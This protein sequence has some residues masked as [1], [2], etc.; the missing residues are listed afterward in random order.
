MEK[1]CVEKMKEGEPRQFLALFDAYFFDVYKYVVRRVGGGGQ[2]DKI[3]REVFFDALGQIQN[4]PVDTSFLVWLYSLARPRV[5]D[6][7]EDAGFPDVQGVITTREKIEQNEGSEDAVKKAEKMF[8][9]L[10]MEEREILRLKFFE[11]V[12]DGDVM[13]ILGIV[14]GTIGPQIYRVLKRA[15][16]LLFGESEGGQGVYFGE[17]SGFLARLRAVEAISSPEILEQTL[18]AEVSGKIDRRDF[19]VEA[20]SFVEKK[21]KKTSYE[22]K[23]APQGSN[24]PAKIFVNAVKE[25][26]QEEEEERI[27]AQIKEERKENLCNFLEKWRLVF[28]LI[29]A[30]VVFFVLFFVV[31]AFLRHDDKPKLIERGYPTIC[32]VDVA[33]EGDF[34]DGEKRSVNRQISNSICD[35]FSVDKLKISKKSIGTVSVFVDAEEQSMEYSFVQKDKNWRI[36]QYVKT[37]NSNEKSG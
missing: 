21:P 33:F 22:E 30:V 5:V 3:V 6:Q 36:K 7:I 9:K 26:K 18:K 37:S 24:D 29:P 32:S 11:E 27:R 12:S 16:F 2:A 19:A 10:S 13:M 28:A 17:I 31:L 34:A 35:Y 25:M 4:T 15:H 23:D 14:D 20:E 8:G 1:Q